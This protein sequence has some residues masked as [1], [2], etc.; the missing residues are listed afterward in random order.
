[1]T[2]E[3]ILDKHLGAF[4][5]SLSPITYG[6]MEDAMDEYAKQQAIAFDEWKILNRWYM[7]DDFKVYQ[8]GTW[9]SEKEELEYANI[10]PEELYVLFIE[11]QTK[12]E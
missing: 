1:M 11:Q 6:R 10:Q 9:S 12:Q 7:T 5:R 2:K 3:G 4:T 8:K